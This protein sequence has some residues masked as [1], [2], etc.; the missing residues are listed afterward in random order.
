MGLLFVFLGVAG[1]IVFFL[2]GIFGI[3]MIPLELAAQHP[4]AP[5]AQPVRWL[6]HQF[7]KDTFMLVYI[8]I[9][10]GIAMILLY[11]ITVF[12]YLRSKPKE[13]NEKD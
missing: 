12:D 2:A 10:M 11:G 3:L 6:R 9:Q 4:D 1:L 7:S 5:I 13:E 8:S